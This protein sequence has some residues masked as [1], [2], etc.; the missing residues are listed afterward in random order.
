MPDPR[1]DFYVTGFAGHS[2]PR[3]ARGVPLAKTWHI[4]SVSKDIEVEA[5][6]ARMKC[7]EVGRV[8]VLDVKAG[9]METIDA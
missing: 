6:K 5:W 7:G 4:G 2:H 3:A 1:I 8:E 9:K